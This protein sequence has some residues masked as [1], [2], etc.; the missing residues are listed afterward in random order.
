MAVQWKKLQRIENSGKIN[1]P[2]N[3]ECFQE[4]AVATH[5]TTIAESCGSPIV[6]YN[7]PMVTGIDISTNSL[8]K[9]AQHPLIR[10][11]KD[12]DVIYNLLV[13]K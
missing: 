3:Y 7:M 1:G 13:Y 11:V 6:I 8:A 5:Y 4:E 10:G 12:S 9:L 2:F